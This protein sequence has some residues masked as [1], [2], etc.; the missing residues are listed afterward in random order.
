MLGCVRCLPLFLRS[1]EA[2]LGFAAER[3][4]SDNERKVTQKWLLR[5]R[6]ESIE[7]LYYVAAAAR[8]V[9]RGCPVRRSVGQSITTPQNTNLTN[10]SYG[11]RVLT[12]SP[13]LLPDPSLLPGDRDCAAGGGL[14]FFLAEETEASFSLS[15]PVHKGIGVW[16]VVF[17]AS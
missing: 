5:R 9:N 14:S 8:L 6:R 1:P 15:D 11:K 10:P 12:R 7:E 2:A 4:G 13:S 17:K 16:R 3:A